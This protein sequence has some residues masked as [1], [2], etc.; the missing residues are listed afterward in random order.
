MS[1]K[2][3]GLDHLT[4]VPNKKKK[5]PRIVTRTPIIVQYHPSNI[6]AVAFALVVTFYGQF[7]LCYNENNNTSPKRGKRCLSRAVSDLV[8]LRQNVLISPHWLPC[9][10]FILRMLPEIRV[11]SEKFSQAFGVIP[12]FV[13]GGRGYRVR[14]QSQ[15]YFKHHVVQAGL[16]WI[17]PS[18][19]RPS[20]RMY[21]TKKKER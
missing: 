9:H 1:A 16:R 7:P 18:N 12:I 13:P 4:P 21:N 11:H 3:Y 17:Q 6:A 2:Q 5:T 10:L 14:V 19:F 20:V 8:Q 15:V